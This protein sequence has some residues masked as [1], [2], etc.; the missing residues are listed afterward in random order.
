MRSGDLKGEGAGAARLPAAGRPHLRRGAGLRQHARLSHRQSGRRSRRGRGHQ[1]SRATPRRSGSSATAPVTGKR[2]SS[3]ISPWPKPCE[4]GRPGVQAHV[5]RVH[6]LGRDLRHRDGACA[7]C[8]GSHLDRGTDSSGARGWLAQD[9]ASIPVP[10]ATGE[11]VYTRWQTRELLA[12]DAVD[13]LQNDP[14]W[15]G[16]ISEQVKIC[17]LGSAFE[18][19]VIAHGHSLLPAPHVAGSQSPATVPFVEYLIRYQE[20]KQYFHR[21]IYRPEQGAVGPAERPDWALSLMR[22]RSR[23]AHR[24][25]LRL[26]DAA[27]SASGSI[28]SST[29]RTWACSG[30]E[31]TS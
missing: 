23:R 6:G 8:R 24:G 1:R 14:D 5:R 29:M 7:G 28:R 12:A 3:R 26:T 31:R 10:V 16:G 25:D 9:R 21:T 19:P 2:A 13:Y 11:H 22:P 20:A 17:A 15:T 4:G 30:G 18:T 27:I